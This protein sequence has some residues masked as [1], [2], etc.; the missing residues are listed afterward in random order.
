MAEAS[1]R[2]YL[3]SILEETFPGITVYYRPPGDVIL[4][5]P[6]I[7]YTKLQREPTYANNLPYSIGTRFQITIISDRPGLMDLDVIF[8]MEN[9]TVVSNNAFMED[10]LAHDI[11]TVT[12]NKI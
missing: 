11:F 3:Q 7:V 8:S 9:V 6:Y 1:D 12:I 4:T 2:L 5:R 10:D